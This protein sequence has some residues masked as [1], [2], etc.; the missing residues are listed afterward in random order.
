MKQIVALPAQALGHGVA[1]KAGNAGDKKF[2][3][4]A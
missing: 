3:L 2:H 4:S 1:D